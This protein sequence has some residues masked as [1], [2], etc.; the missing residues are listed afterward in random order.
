MS[1]CMNPTAVFL[2]CGTV[3]GVCSTIADD[4]T[5]REQP[6]ITLNGTLLASAPDFSV[7]KCPATDQFE[8]TYKA[9][10]TFMSA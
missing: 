5:C 3:T 9:P 6:C 10:W 7:I 8:C 1:R 2:C 4:A